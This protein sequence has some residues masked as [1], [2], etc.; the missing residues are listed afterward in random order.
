M[1]EIPDYINNF[2]K[3]EINELNK[4]YNQNINQFGYGCLILISKNKNIDV[5]FL[6]KDLL[7]DKYKE[8]FKY[9]DLNKKIFIIID[10]ENKEYHL[11]IHN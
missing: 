1:N 9:L 4:I 5:S 8:N 6:T 11:E 2:L 10:K 7:M 3:R